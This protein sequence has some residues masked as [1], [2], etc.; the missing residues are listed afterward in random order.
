[1]SELKMGILS[2]ALL[3]GALFALAKETGMDLRIADMASQLVQLGTDLLHRL[4]L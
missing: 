3:G 4:Q 2:L 1:M